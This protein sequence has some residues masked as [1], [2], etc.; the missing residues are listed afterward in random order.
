MYERNG[1]YEHILIKLG[2]GV[3]EYICERNTKFR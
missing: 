2:A 3:P 1:K